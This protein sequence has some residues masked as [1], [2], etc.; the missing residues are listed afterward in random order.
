[1]DTGQFKSE[2]EKKFPKVIQGIL[3]PHPRRMTIE[4]EA[5]ALLD[6]ADYIFNREKCRFIIATALHTKDGFEIYYHFSHDH[7][8]IVLNIHVILPHE[9][10]AVESLTKLLSGAEWIEREMHELFGID[11]IGHPNLVPLISAG[12][13]E[14]GT[15]PYRKDFTS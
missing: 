7:S 1:M 9:K 14:E 12:N 5:T 10:P 2:L 4:I 6:I 8:G 11:F 3:E 15:Y 13:W